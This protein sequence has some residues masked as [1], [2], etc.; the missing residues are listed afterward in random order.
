M[1]GEMVR[2]QAAVADKLEA[3]L[4]LQ[5]RVRLVEPGAVERTPGVRGHV[6][7]LRAED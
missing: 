4:G 1:L 2:F 7:D 3:S 6:L 5:A